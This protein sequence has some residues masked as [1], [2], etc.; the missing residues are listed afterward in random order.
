MNQVLRQLGGKIC[1]F[2]GAMG[3]MLQERGLLPGESPE[4]WG[5]AHREEIVQIHR[6]YLEAGAD[7][8]KTNTFGANR[9]K[10]EGSGHTV[11]EV[12]TAGVET[13]CRRWRP[14]ATARY[15]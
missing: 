6:A 1:H 13:R 7:F 15:F 9:F 5:L 8:L 2:D 11:E 4:L 10:L 12:V 14:A 3:T